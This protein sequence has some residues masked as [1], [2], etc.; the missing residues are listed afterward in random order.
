VCIPAVIEAEERLHEINFTEPATADP[1]PVGTGMLIRAIAFLISG[2][3]D[4]HR[5][6]RVTAA[7]LGLVASATSPEAPK[8]GNIP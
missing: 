5:L 7:G 3:A 2:R 6:N 1:K 4:R 8:T